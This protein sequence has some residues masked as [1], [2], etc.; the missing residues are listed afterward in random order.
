MACTKLVRRSNFQTTRQ[1]MRHEPL[2][3]DSPGAYRSVAWIHKDWYTDPNLGNGWSTDWEEWLEI[4]RFFAEHVD[5][6]LKIELLRDTY[7]GVCGT[8]EML[9]YLE[10]SSG[11]YFLFTAGGRYY[12]WADGVLTVHEKEFAGPR[13]FLE[14][15]LDGYENKP[16]VV[17][18][19]RDATTRPATIS[20]LAAAYAETAAP[21]GRDLKHYIF[22]N[23]GKLKA[24]LVERFERYTRAGG[25]TADAVSLFKAAASMAANAQKQQQHQQRA[26]PALHTA[27]RQAAADE[28]ARWRAQREEAQRSDREAGFG[29]G[30]VHP[31]FRSSYGPS[32]SSAYSSSTSGSTYGSST[33]GGAGAQPQPTYLSSVSQLPRAPPPVASGARPPSLLLL[34]LVFIH[35]RSSLGGSPDD[36]PAR[37]HAKGARF[38]LAPILKRVKRVGTGAAELRPAQHR[39]RRVRAVPER[40]GGVI[41]ATARGVWAWGEPD[42]LHV[43]LFQLRRVGLGLKLRGAEPVLSLRL[44]CALQLQL[45]FTLPSFSVEPESV[46]NVLSVQYPRAGGTRVGVGAG[47][48]REYG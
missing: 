22:E 13:E 45:H 15:A 14:H 33:G 42:E 46:A 5:G 19:P 9:A 29:D 36:P 41:P 44:F 48:R 31:E 43:A 27:A 3:P 39:R 40:R 26:P 34:L 24:A 8:V 21:P 32:S 18:T 37:P 20:E 35:L 16:N 38:C 47:E 12:F 1:P 17:P 11:L 10:G 30:G 25:S 4:E 28:A 23:L 6:R 7:E 2:R